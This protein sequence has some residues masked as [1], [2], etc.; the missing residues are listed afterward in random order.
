MVGMAMR[1][2]AR[3]HKLNCDGGYVYGKINGRYVILDE[4]YG[5]KRLRIYLY[6]P[7]PDPE[8]ESKV[9]QRVLDVLEDVE[10]AQ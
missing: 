8:A 6:P 1:R 2:Y 7:A 9:A 10:K 4:G 3:K 5:F